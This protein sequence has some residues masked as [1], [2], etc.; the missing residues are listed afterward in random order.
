M[1]TMVIVLLWPA[2]SSCCAGCVLKW[3]TVR[4]MNNWR[5]VREHLMFL[6]IQQCLLLVGG[7]RGG[8]DLWWGFRW[9]GI[10]R[11]NLYLVNW[12]LTRMPSR[13]DCASLEERWTW[14]D[15]YI[16]CR[17]G[18]CNEHSVSYTILLYLIDCWRHDTYLH[19]FN[20]LIF[21]IKWASHRKLGKQSKASLSMQIKCDSIIP[22]TASSWLLR[23]C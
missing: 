7:R 10:V 6:K 4:P 23:C 1:L 21:E 8:T 19:S 9:L 12:N 13:K 11:P 3:C 14:W 16:V 17:D 15:T 22:S 5:K 20:V 18:D 2:L